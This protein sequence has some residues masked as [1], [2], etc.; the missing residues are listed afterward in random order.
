MVCGLLD[1]AKAGSL[2]KAATNPARRRNGLERADHFK[3]RY[4][5]TEET[6]SVED[7]KERLKVD[8]PVEEEPAKE[9]PDVAV[10]LKNLGRQ[11][12]ETLQTAWKSEEKQRVE[13]EVRQGMK[14]FVEEVDKAFRNLKATPAAQKVKDEAEQVKEK[15]ETGELGRKARGGLVQGLQWLSD[16]LAKL[17][18]QFTVSEKSPDDPVADEESP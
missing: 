18:D 8:I 14:S 4:V 1:V 17:A 11:F 16:E 3:E 13:D 15:V 5:M 12:A 10:E 2:I 7:I 6:P 9:K